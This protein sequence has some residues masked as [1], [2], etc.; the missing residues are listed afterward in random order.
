MELVLSELI[1][2]LLG[3]G[4][5]LT[6]VSRT[7]KVPAHD[8]LTWVHVPGPGR[9][10]PLAY[11]WF[12]ILGSLITWRRR[13]GPVLST[14]AIVA[15][16]V[17]WTAVHFCHH[18]TERM[19][20]SRVSRRTPWYRLNAWLSNRLKAIGERY[21]YS[22]K[23]TGGLIG[24]SRGVS[25]EVVEHFP[26]VPTVTIPNG[27]SLARFHPDERSRAEIRR[28]HG[29]AGNELVALF[30]GSEW[31]R[32]GLQ[33]AIDA[34][35][36][37]PDWKLLVVGDGNVATYRTHARASAVE[38]RVVFVGT[39]SDPAPYYCASDAFVLPTSYET[40]SLVT[41]EAAATGVPLLVTPVN[42]VTDLLVD[43]S[44][45]W[46]IDRD[47]KQIGA[48]LHS[49]GGDPRQRIDMGSA[50][51]SAAEAFTWRRMVSA[52]RDVLDRPVSGNSA[53]ASLPASSTTVTNVHAHR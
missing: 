16:H 9:P 3:D 49:L 12:F 42:G 46:F 52:Y 10:F 53:V 41:Y 32:K 34:L 2:G 15:N 45:G 50:G 1:G 37:A 19:G 51:R 48:R 33:V 47:P 17:D 35:T 28:R 44:N 4:Y 23:R 26:D 36:H 38:S 25:A 20:L 27:V 39:V 6:V 22:L 14:G 31:E 21:C 29:L 13:S 8:R 43:G 18:A 30:V 24:V 40:F 11:P 7:C 5:Q